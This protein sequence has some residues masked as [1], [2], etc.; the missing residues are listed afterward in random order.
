MK[1]TFHLAFASGDLEKAKEF[2]GNFLNCKV[3]RSGPSWVDYDFF[4][5]QLTIQYL[6]AKNQT[7]SNF[8]HPSSGF[9]LNHWGIILNWGD[10]H[11]LKDKL[12]AEG[13]EFA[14]PPQVAMEGEVGEQ[15]ILM[16][17]DP[18]G[19][20]LEFKSFEDAGAVFR[21]S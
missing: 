15:N 12:V 9:P 10:W 2:Y 3:G 17:R 20:V 8:H 13:V 18:D 1:G 6:S 14:V 11:T 21:S 5:H 7:Y 19:N 16:L 4:G